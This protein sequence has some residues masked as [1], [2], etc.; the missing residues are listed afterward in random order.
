MVQT[1][2]AQRLTGAKKRE[3]ITPVFTQ[4][5]WLPVK[6]RIDFKVVL[7][8]F[9]RVLHGLSPQCIADLKLSILP[10]GQ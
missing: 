1:A 3:H 2:A 4:L 6:F 10:P 8:F 5:H 7:L 9:Y